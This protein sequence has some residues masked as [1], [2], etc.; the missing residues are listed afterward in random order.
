[1]NDKLK[2]RELEA[3][4]CELKKLLELR[5]KSIDDLIRQNQGLLREYLDL[6]GERG[7]AAK[8]S[9]PLYRVEQ[10]DNGYGMISCGHS[11][12]GKV[13]SHEGNLYRCRTCF[14]YFL[15]NVSLESKSNSSV[16]FCV[17]RGDENVCLE[18]G[19]PCR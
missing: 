11:N 19:K 10:V 4:V 2:I 13:H 8:P 18:C 5:D 14:T 9:K 17:T 12:S 16:H 7:E 3:Q 1:M 15:L 6:R